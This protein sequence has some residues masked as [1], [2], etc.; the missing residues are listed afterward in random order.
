MNNIERRLEKLENSPNAEAGPDN[1]RVYVLHRMNDGQ[2]YCPVRETFYPDEKAF[3][4]A[5]GK[6]WP[7]VYL[8]TTSQNCSPAEYL[9]QRK[10]TEADLADWQPGEYAAGLLAKGISPAI[11]RYLERAAGED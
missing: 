10:Q 8:H 5:M 1:Q 7:D 4:S 9:E 11:A 2:I 6:A 3:L